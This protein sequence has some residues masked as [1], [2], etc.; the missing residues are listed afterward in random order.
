L[1]QIQG[2]DWPAPGP[3]VENW[4]KG[5]YRSWGEDDLRT[6]K[7]SVGYVSS[8]LDGFAEQF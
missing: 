6:E 3:V 8:I 1:P 2:R 4:M 5:F 7:K